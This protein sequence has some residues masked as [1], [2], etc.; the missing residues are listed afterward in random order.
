MKEPTHRLM[1]MYS[2]GTAEALD[3]NVESFWQ[4]VPYTLL[5]S[6]EKF[7]KADMVIAVHLRTGETEVLKNRYGDSGTLRGRLGVLR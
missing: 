2:D 7:H 6:H 1:A 5:L 4:R 3:V